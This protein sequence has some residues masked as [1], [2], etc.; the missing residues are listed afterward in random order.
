M[1]RILVTGVTGQV[2]YELLNTLRELGDVKGLTRQQADL[3]QPESLIE[4][5]REWRP[6]VIINPAAY[7]AV[8][9]A[10]SETDLAMRVNRDAPGILAEQAKALGALLIHFSTDYVFDGCQN[11]PYRENDPTG[12]INAY[13]TSK[14]AGEQAI[15]AAGGD[16]L[17][18]RTAWVY[19]YR[20]NNFLNSM[21]RLMQEREE[22]GIVADQRGCP[23]SA[24]FLADAT[25][26][27]VERAQKKRQQGRFES[28]IYHLTCAG[29]ASW[30][31]FAAAIREELLG[32]KQ[33]AALAR[34]NPIN[35]EDYPTPAKRAAYSVLDCGKI[36]ERYRIQRP[37]WEEAL[38][39]VMGLVG[40][41]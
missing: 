3:S 33:N 14:L 22:L 5:I 26:D 34:L 11:R 19:S 4:P 31:E 38:R 25:A 8:D 20:G 30:Y 35:T 10:E 1:T 7:T 21:I 40:S 13:G 41:G 37:E 2:G 39:V 6:E 28:D 18:L 32:K 17:I 9:K 16:Y 23:T 15:Q 27:I 29:E 12:P 24:L 36:L